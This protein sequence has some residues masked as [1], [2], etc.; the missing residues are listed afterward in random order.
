[1]SIGG[2]GGGANAPSLL[3][4]SHLTEMYILKKKNSHNTTLKMSHR[5]T[6]QVKKNVIKEE[7][8]TPVHG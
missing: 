5:P 2:G 4:Q 1:M 7:E 6:L 8:G 3:W